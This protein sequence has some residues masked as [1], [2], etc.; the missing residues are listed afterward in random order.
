MTIHVLRSTVEGTVERYMYEAPEC[1]DP[2]YHST[3]H[4]WIAF[5]D[6][7]PPH[8]M[9]TVVVPCATDVEGV[10]LARFAADAEIGEI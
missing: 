8:W 6:G 7:P 3:A 10:T 2:S 9:S 1:F 4:I 5:F